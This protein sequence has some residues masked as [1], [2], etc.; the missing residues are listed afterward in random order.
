M[1]YNVG[2]SLFADKSSGLERFIFLSMAE[3]SARLEDLARGGP[4]LSD[5][6]RLEKPAKQHLGVMRPCHLSSSV[7]PVTVGH[8]CTYSGHSGR[9]SRPQR[10]L[11]I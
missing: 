9:H 8:V 7:I 3:L 1:G 6:V 4:S 11:Y 5:V 2:F 10:V